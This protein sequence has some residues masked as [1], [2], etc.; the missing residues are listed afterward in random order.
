MKTA[1]LFS[2]QGAQYAGMGREL[3]DNYIVCRQAF[4]EADE[5]LGFKL[6]KLCFSD[7]P[8]LNDTQFC[9]PATFVLS[10]AAFRLLKQSDICGDIYAGFSLGE[11]TAL[12]AAGVFGFADAVRLVYARGMAMQEAA[13]NSKGGMSAVLGAS[14]ELAEEAC[15][16]AGNVWCANY[17]TANQTVIS[18]ELSALERAEQYL[19]ANGVKK[20]I[21]LNVSGAFHTEL[22]LPAK[23]KLETELNKIEK[24]APVVS[25]IEN[26]TALEY[27]SD[28]A[29]ALCKQLTGAV[30]WHGTMERLFAM[31]VTRFI[32]LGPGRTLTG[33][34]RSFKNAGA[35]AMNIEN[36]ATFE[37]ALKNIR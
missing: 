5:A 17:N 11:Y 7:D 10:T 15:K 22:I 20:V 13:A 16:S 24:K 3:Y 30:N 8:R 29:A 28:I 14:P 36:P 6:S 32:E 9:Q 21:R 35:Q 27:S 25:V 23:D 2:G 19:L 31:G 37:A 33:F 1:F 4:D 34:V 26:T 12:A 18:G